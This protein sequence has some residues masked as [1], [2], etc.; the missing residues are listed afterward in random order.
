VAA[1]VPRERIRELGAHGQLQATHGR[2]LTFPGRLD[3]GSHL[4]P[5]ARRIYLINCLAAIQHPLAQHACSRLRAAKL[6]E[7][8]EAHVSALVGGEVGTVLAKTKLAEILERIRF[9]QVGVPLHPSARMGH[10]P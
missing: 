2:R 5:G 1:E 3:D 10:D 9:Y 4:S 7:L 8:M 6:G